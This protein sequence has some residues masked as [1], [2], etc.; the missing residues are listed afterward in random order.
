MK[1]LAVGDIVGK[2]GLNQLKAC[3]P[4][5]MQEHEIDFCIVNG[6]NAAERNGHYRKN[7]SRH[8]KT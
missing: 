7:V 4:K 3:L 2:N 1:I 6:E 8:F 5:V